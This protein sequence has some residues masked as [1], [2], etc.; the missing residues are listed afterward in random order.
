MNFNLLKTLFK[1]LSLEVSKVD[2]EEKLI[3][4]IKNHKLLIEYLNILKDIFSNILFWFFLQTIA[5]ITI[6]TVSIVMAKAKVSNFE[7]VFFVGLII[8][9]ILQISFT[10]YFGTGLNESLK[11]FSTSLYLCSWYNQSKCFKTNLII[12]VDL[13]SINKEL[14]AGGFFL[15]NLQTYSIILYK[16][17]S[18]YMVFRNV[19]INKCAR[20]D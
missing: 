10:C 1:V 7:F 17:Y 2:A 4:V 19:I 9:F 12:L 14:K 11:N 6:Y 13:N 3:C 5:I 18:F 20:F 16:I 15:I 8:C